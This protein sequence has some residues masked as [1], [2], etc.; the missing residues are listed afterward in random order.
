MVVGVTAGLLAAIEFVAP[1]ALGNIP[2]LAFGR[3]RPIHTNLMLLGWVPAAL[4]GGVLYV[5]PR[6]LGV[7]LWSERLGNFSMW[8]FNGVL[9]GGVITLSMGY[10][11][12]REY[13]EMVRPLDFIVLLWLATLVTNLMMCVRH[14]KENVL[15]VSVWYAIGGLIWTFFVY[16]IGNVVWSPHGSIP[17]VTD[18]LW[19]WFYGHNTVGL[20]LTPPAIAI[21]Y[22]VIPRVT[23]APLW[24]HN[25]SLIGFWTILAI[26]THTG[27]HHL[28]QAP[29]PTWIKVLAVVDSI[30]MLIPVFT[31]LANVWMP[32]KERWGRIHA[33]I[34][35][36]FVFAGTVWYALTC[37]QGPLQ[38][39][40]SIQ[41]VTH[42]THWVVAH[43]HMA[44][45]GFAGMIGMG[46]IYYLLPRVSG[47]KV[48][49]LKIA[50][51]QYWIMLFGV[52]SFFIVL[53]IAGLV[54][55][56][57][58]INGEMVYR[59]LPELRYYMI[60]RGATGVL[61]TCGAVLQ[62]VNVVM[63]IY[64]GEVTSK[65]PQLERKS[66]TDEVGEAL[67]EVAS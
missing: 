10:T 24:S 45:F 50:E 67:P 1:D 16:A 33:D 21:A 41:R 66:S 62:L 7:Q 52:T 31:F 14:R 2:W 12:G 25:L 51:L 29:V 23:K 48:W 42:F 22:W 37:I 6:V 63:T 3:L 46:A 11:Q 15:Y 30:C 32:L 38:S 53:T 19:L 18:S 27:A 13:A 34:G 17:G 54:Q 58:W 40:P 28:L 57:G 26:Y 55:G 49:S 20:F 8:A 59:V 35:G 4:V 64:F 36:K 5:V 56:H 47:R 65:E 9:V 44:V 43:S 39:L 61:I 60:L